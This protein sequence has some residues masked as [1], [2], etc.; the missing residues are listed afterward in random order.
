MAKIGR[1]QPCPCGSGKKYKHCCL[2]ARQLETQVLEQ[3]QIRVTLTQAIEKIQQAAAEQRES[4]FEL[5]VFIFFSSAA[6][7]AW[8]LEVTDSDAVQVAEAGRALEVPI[9][10]DSETI[11][12]NWSH[13]FAMRAKQLYLTAY[14]DKAE[15]RLEDAPCQQINAAVR[16]VRKRYAP[17]MLEQVHLS[18]G[19][20][21][22]GAQER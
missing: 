10:E 2:S 22:E 1:N 20:S 7:D 16:R 4:F 6:G 12:M 8:L 21:G 5:G 9:E 18:K 3:H 15:H 17:E 11:E 14:A 19:E 13:T